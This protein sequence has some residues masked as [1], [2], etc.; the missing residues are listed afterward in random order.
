MWWP[1][2]HPSRDHQVVKGFGQAL[3]VLLEDHRPASLPARRLQL[4]D[5]GLELCDFVQLEGF[6]IKLDV[7][8]Y[9][10]SRGEQIALEVVGVGEVRELEKLLGNLKAEVCIV[11]LPTAADILGLLENCARNTNLHEPSGYLQSGDTGA[12]NGDGLHMTEVVLNCWKDCFCNASTERLG[13]LRGGMQQL[14]DAIHELV[15]RAMF[16][17]SGS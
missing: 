11:L 15:L 7:R 3:L 12:D 2:V 9:F 16:W 13:L 10:W 17:A 5:R 4:N 1:A 6:C 8:L 14:V